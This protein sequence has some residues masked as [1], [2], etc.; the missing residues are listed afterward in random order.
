MTAIPIELSVKLSDVTVSGKSK[1]TA[2]K[3]LM[4]AILHFSLPVSSRLTVQHYHYAYLI[5]GP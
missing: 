1:M 3:L 2:S 5:V 4:A